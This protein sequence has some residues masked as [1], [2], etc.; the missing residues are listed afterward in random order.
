MK[1]VLSEKNLR[2]TMETLS[3]FVEGKEQLRIYE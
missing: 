2:I 3:F 1:L